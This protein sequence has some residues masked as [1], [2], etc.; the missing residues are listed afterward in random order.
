[1]EGRKD[2]STVICFHFLPIRQLEVQHVPRVIYH[3]SVA[4]YIGH[5]NQ[6][7]HLKLNSV[8]YCYQMREAPNL[9]AM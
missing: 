2:S 3:I 4:T 5:L 1:M 6:E 8:G 7:I 9:V